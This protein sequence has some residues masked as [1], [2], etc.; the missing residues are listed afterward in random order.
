ML[1]GIAFQVLL[2]NRLPLFFFFFF[3]STTRPPHTVSPW[4]MNTNTCAHEQ[5][6]VG[7]RDGGSVLRFAAV[8]PPS[9]CVI[10][11]LGRE[12]GRSRHAVEAL[13]PRGAFST[14][15]PSFFLLPLLRFLLLLHVSFLFFSISFLDPLPALPHP[16]PV[17]LR[18]LL[19]LPLAYLLLAPLPPPAAGLS[20]SCHTVI[21]L[22][23]PCVS[24][25]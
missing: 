2:F 23:A 16:F 8:Q 6:A 9:R 1:I 18:I 12:E 22:P 25:L 5:L 3:N 24:A 14:S 7:R 4:R 10:R 11:V 13:C 17:S 21:G 15:S 20:D 19:L